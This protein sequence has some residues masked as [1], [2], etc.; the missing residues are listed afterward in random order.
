MSSLKTLETNVIQKRDALVEICKKFGK[1][2]SVTVQT[3]MSA[4]K[5]LSDASAEYNAALNKG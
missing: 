4:Q 3:I 2:P 1:D 5:A